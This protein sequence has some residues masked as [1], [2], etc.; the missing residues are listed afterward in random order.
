MLLLLLLLLLCLCG[1]GVVQALAV[2]PAGNCQGLKVAP[3]RH[4]YSSVSSRSY[5]TSLLLNLAVRRQAPTFPS[6]DSSIYSANNI[7][8]CR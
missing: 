4:T 1:F 7:I 6:G 8:L 2:G 5:N 3:L